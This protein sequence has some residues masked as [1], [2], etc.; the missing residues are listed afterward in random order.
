MFVLSIEATAGLCGA[1]CRIGAKLDRSQSALPA[2]R[3]DHGHDY[4][5]GARGRDRF[6]GQFGPDSP[7]QHVDLEA[8]CEV[9]SDRAPSRHVWLVKTGILRFQH[10]SYDG[11]RQ[12]LSLALPGEIVGYGREW[13][14]GMSL[15]TATQGSLCRI[16]K[17]DYDRSLQSDYR[18]RTAFYIQQQ[19][20]LDRLRWL[21][22]LIG[23]LRPDERLSAFLAVSTRFMPCQPL[24]DGTAVL[25]MLLSRSDIAD[26]LATSVESIS[27]I[28]HKLDQAGVIEIKDP[29]HFRIVNLQGLTGLGKI[30]H[31][32]DHLPFRDRRFQGHGNALKT[33]ACTNCEFKKAC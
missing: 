18:L 12:I 10:Y 7:G 17:R 27:R 4:R 8:D 26:L 29:A 20:Q 15:E 9:I 11:K 23:A 32:F 24:P 3:A 13:R 1:V 14:E 2:S 31:A 6:L 16:D 21:T 33:I 30:D 19:D 22:W 25:S 5:N 28:V